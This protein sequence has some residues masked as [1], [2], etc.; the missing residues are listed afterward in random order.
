[1]TGEKIVLILVLCFGNM[2]ALTDTSLINNNHYFT[3]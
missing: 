3:T 2:S 1:M